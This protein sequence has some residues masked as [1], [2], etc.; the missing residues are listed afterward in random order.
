MKDFEEAF[1]YE[2]QKKKKKSSIG[3]KHLSLYDFKFSHFSFIAFSST[4]VPYRYLNIKCK[5]LHLFGIR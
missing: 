2:R 4:G 1:P 3:L 5:I